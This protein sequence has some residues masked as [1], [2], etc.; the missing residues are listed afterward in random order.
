MEGRD[1]FGESRGLGVVGIEEMWE[2]KEMAE[3]REQKGFLFSGD[4]W[5]KPKPRP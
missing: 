3:L 4:N 5:P 1:C 2:E